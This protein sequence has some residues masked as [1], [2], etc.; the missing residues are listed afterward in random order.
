LLRSYFPQVQLTNDPHKA[1]VVLSLDASFVEA[2]EEGYRLTVTSEGIQ[3]LAATPTGLFY[4]LQTLRQMLPAQQSGSVSLPWVEIEDAPTFGWRGFMLDEA[5][6]FFG[7]E[8]VK[9]VLDWMAFLKLNIFHW[10]LTDYQGW[11]VEIN[12]IRC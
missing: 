5:R 6:H 4:G 12:S 11:R 9:H 1:A 3:L 2:G 10:H 7:T 8:T